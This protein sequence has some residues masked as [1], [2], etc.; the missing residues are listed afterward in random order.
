MEVMD[1]E[2]S[3]DRGGRNMKKVKI[4]PQDGPSIELMMSVDSLNS[5]VY[6]GV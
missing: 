3:R 6:R 4:Y 5:T 2:A 1:S